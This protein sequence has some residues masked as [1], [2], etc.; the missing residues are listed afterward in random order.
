MTRN[1]H[2]SS[3][4]G[5]IVV[6]VHRALD[7]RDGEAIIPGDR[8]QEGFKLAIDRRGEPFTGVTV[9]PFAIADLNVLFLQVDPLLGNAGL[10]E[11]TSDM[12][13]QLEGRGHPVEFLGQLE[14]SQLDLLL[15]DFPLFLGD[16]S[17]M[18]ARAM[19]FVSA[20]PRRIASLIRKERNFTSMR[21]VL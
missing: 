18:R 9:L 4:N 6:S 17:G 2:S 15:G 5:S 7:G 20:W 19:P 3:A 14:A 10:G 16:G 8:F 1:S 12:E 11:A 13:L 21:A